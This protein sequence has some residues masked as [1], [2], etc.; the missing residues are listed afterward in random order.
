MKNCLTN[1]RILV[2]PFRTNFLYK[3]KE[4]TNR[5]LFNNNNN[6]ESILCFCAKCFN[7]GKSVYNV[8]TYNFLINV[9][10]TISSNLDIG[11]IFFSYNEQVPRDNESVHL[12]YYKPYLTVKETIVKQCLY[13]SFIEIKGTRRNDRRNM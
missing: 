10:E 2:F 3:P 6:R 7:V 4:V 12:D 9:I 11:F 1:L 13:L 5:E 8:T